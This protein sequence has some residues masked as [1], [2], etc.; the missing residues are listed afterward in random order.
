MVEEI[1]VDSVSLVVEN[2]EFTCGHV[3]SEVVYITNDFINDVGMAAAKSHAIE[4]A[5]ERAKTS[6]CPHCEERAD[7]LRTLLPGYHV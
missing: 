7:Y 1:V 4:W 6:K 2:I 5:H 3:I